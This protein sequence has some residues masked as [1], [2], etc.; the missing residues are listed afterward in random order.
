[1][2]IRESPKGRWSRLGSGTRDHPKV[3]DQ[4]RLEE[5]GPQELEEEK[6]ALG[7]IDYAKYIH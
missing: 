3:W 6:P 4:R 5:K 1:M 2:G 7:H